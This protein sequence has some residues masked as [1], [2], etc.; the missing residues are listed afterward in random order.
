MIGAYQPRM[1]SRRA[2]LQAPCKDCREKV[3]GCHDHCEAFAQ[4]KQR[5][6]EAKAYH[7][8]NDGNEISSPL[9]R[10]KRRGYT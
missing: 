2:E 10:I 1:G 7:R 4:Y 8:K 5:L 9:A 6:E 3:P